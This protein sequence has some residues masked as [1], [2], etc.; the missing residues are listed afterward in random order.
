MDKA[1]R[2]LGS[3]LRRRATLFLI[4][5]FLDT[6]FA[7][8]LRLASLRH[9]TVAVSIQDPAEASLPALGWLVCED[10]ETGELLEFDTSDPAFRHGFEVQRLAR[11]ASLQETLRRAGVDA[12]S[13]ETGKP[14]QRALLQF[15]DRRQQR[16]GA[17]RGASG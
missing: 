8:A 13:C 1:L 4:S 15:F 7:R 11:T 9:D 5:D 6:G 10:A 2:T 12:V 3:L 14:Y 16:L 17:A